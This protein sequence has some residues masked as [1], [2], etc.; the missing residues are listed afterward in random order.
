MIL[1]EIHNKVL[2]SHMNWISSWKWNVE[3][4]VVHVIT[5]LLIF[6]FVMFYFFKFLWNK[7]VEN[8]MENFLLEDFRK[9]GLIFF[10]C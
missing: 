4:Q 5:S 6:Y 9:Q 1:F 10:Y 7:N 8:R 2:Y 3:P